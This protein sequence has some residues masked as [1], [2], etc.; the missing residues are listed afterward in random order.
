MKEHYFLGTGCFPLLGAITYNRC[1]VFLIMFT[2]SVSKKVPY[3]YLDFNKIF[4]VNVFEIGSL[5][6]QI[7]C[8]GCGGRVHLLGI[9]S[10][11]KNYSLNKNL[12]DVREL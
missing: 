10:L 12:N 11:N 2:S 4:I 5:K 3:V 8:T 7:K 6:C 1:R 9:S